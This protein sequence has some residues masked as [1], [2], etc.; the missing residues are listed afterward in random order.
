MNRAIDWF[1]KNPVAAN[2]LMVLIITSGVVTAFT[3]K[4]EVFPEIDLDQIS[5]TVE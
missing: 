2:L 5:I 3:I 4:K 1:A